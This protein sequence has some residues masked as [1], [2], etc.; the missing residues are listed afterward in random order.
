MKKTIV[1]ILGLALVS[2]ACGHKELP[3]CGDTTTNV[4]SNVQV[5]FNPDLYGGYNKPDADSIIRLVNGR[6]VLKKIELPDYKRNIDLTAK[7]TLASNGDRWDKSGSCFVLPKESVINLVNIAKGER[8]FPEVDSTRFEHLAGIVP[9]TD[10]KPT[11]ELMRFMTPFGVGFYSSESDSLSSKRKPVYIDQWA[12]NVQWEQNITDLYSQLQGEAY[13]GVFIDTWSPE[14]YTVSLTLEAKETPVTCEALPRQHVEPLL[15][16]VYYVG[17]GYPDIF[18]RK[19]VSVDFDLPENAR[20][21]RLKYIVTGHGGHSGGD[22]FVQKENI[23]RIDSTEVL[24]FT[25]WRTDCASFRRFNPATGVWLQKRLASYIGRGGYKEKEVEEPVASSDF[26]RSNWCPG[27][28][29]T[30]ECVSLPRL[31][32]GSHTVTFSIPEAQ[33][34]NGNELNHWLVSSYLVWEE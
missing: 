20:N 5:C 10:Y 9:G 19:N 30:P 18:A 28:D 4:F 33:A 3:A 1:F 34:I 13:V 7:I 29:V 2:G 16:T 15:N 14:G 25:P 11:L 8:K 31:E 21:V 32:A 22:E 6:I 17:Q 24:H 26:S 27:S 12:K 23:I